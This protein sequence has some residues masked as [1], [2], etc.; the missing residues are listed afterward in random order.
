MFLFQGIL[1]E[2]D[3]EPYVFGEYEFVEN[4]T[5]LQYFPVKNTD[6][7]TRPFNL[8]ELRIESNHGH[9]N[10]TCLYRFRVHG[11]IDRDVFRL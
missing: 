8:V 5:S 9:M 3:P 11:T 1:T 10:Y 4:G 7:N 6:E 2:N